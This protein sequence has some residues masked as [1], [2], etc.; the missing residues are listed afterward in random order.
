MIDSQ[1]FF[2]DPALKLHLPA[3]D[4]SA[5]TL[6]VNTPTA[7]PGDTLSYT[8]TLANSSPFTVTNATVAVDYDEP[9]GQVT[10]TQEPGGVAP[11]AIRGHSDL[12]GAHAGPGS[13]QLR[14][15]LLLNAAF[16]S[17]VTQINAPTTISALLRRR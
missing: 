11:P 17:G 1:V 15:D 16:P 13:M 9:H 8:V 12:D 2:G 5:S 10:A 6:A 3:A 14:F 7:Q 4:L